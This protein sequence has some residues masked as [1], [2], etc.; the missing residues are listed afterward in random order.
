MLEEVI[1]LLLAVDRQCFLPLGI[2]FSIF[3][4]MGI[5]G[6]KG[7]LHEARFL[8]FSLKKRLGLKPFLRR[9]KTKKKEIVQPREVVPGPP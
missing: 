5:L 6:P 4:K 7:R 3:D 1:L 9:S 2:S 8:F